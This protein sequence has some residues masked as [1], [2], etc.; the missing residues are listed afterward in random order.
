MPGYQIYRFSFKHSTVPLPH[1]VPKT[2]E[3]CYRIEP[4]NERDRKFIIFRMRTKPESIQIIAN[5]D[6]KSR[7]ISPLHARRE[8]LF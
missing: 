4:T 2:Y 1:G 3:F 7:S 6:R 5:A 8:P